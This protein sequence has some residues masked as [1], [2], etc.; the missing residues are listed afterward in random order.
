MKAKNISNRNPRY[1]EFNHA[2]LGR[3]RTLT[4]TT[5]DSVITVVTSISLRPHYEENRIR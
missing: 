3:G 4:Q 2:V 5:M 1:C